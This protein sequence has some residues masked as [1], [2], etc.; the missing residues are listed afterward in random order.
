VREDY[1]LEE[2]HA[3]ISILSEIIGHEHIEKLL[4]ILDLEDHEKAVEEFE[5]VMGIPLWI[6][7]DWFSDINDEEIIKSYIKYDFNK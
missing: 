5:S 7:S 2:K 6:H 1:G 3:D 4:K